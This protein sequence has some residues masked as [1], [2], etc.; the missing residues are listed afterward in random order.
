MCVSVGVWGCEC[1]CGDVH[2]VAILEDWQFWKKQLVLRN[3][4]SYEQPMRIKQCPNGCSLRNITNH[5]K[6]IGSSTCSFH[7]RLIEMCIGKIKTQVT[8]ALTEFT[9]TNCDR[10]MELTESFLLVYRYLELIMAKCLQCLMESLHKFVLFIFASSLPFS[11]H[12]L[13]TF[14]LRPFPFFLPLSYLNRWMLTSRSISLKSTELLGSS[15]WTHRLWGRPS[16]PRPWGAPAGRML[17][18]RFVFPHSVCL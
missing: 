11:L 7:F 16:A 5:L 1:E 10:S 18:T 4:L 3:S 13:P 2:I 17:L 12:C 15:T 14:S 6:L 9:M 8:S